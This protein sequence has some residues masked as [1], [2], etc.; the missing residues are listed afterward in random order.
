MMYQLLILGIGGGK[1]KTKKTFRKLL[2]ELWLTQGC[3]AAA[4]Y[5]NELNELMT[6]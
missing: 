3:Y 1:T 2:N 6:V 4:D 5:G